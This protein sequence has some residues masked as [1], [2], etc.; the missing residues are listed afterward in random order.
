MKSF[1]T[2]II[3]MAEPREIDKS[4][5][6]YHGTSTYSN[7]ESII[8]TGI[9]PP[10]LSNRKGYLR[11]VEGKVYITSSLNYAVIYA[12]GGNVI[13]HEWYDKDFK[14]NEKYG[15][16]CVINGNELNGKI[17]PDEDDIG[18]LIYDNTAPYW[19][20]SLMNKYIARSSIQ[21]VKDGEYNYFAKVG[22][23]LL[24]KMTPT[25]KIELIDYG[26]S[27]AHTGSLYP[28][29][30][31]KIDKLQS[32]NLLKDCSNFFELAERIK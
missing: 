11:P 32:I 19:L 24:N 15:Y 5:I 12:L 3:E 4:K 26:T 14:R 31:W 10:D 13:G 17:Q 18:K 8:K 22:K 25:Q 21:R 29:E 6:Y 2:F 30:I 20:I 27:I 1:K 16:L 7:I 9:N 28:S 23:V